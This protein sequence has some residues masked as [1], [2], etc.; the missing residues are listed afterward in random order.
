MAEDVSGRK[1][2]GQPKGSHVILAAALPVISS[3]YDVLSAGSSV[4]V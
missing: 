2:Q 4:F 1:D 3:P